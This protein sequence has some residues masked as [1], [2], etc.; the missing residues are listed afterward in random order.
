MQ[1]L[2]SLSIDRRRNWLN[3]GYPFARQVCL[4]SGYL[5]LTWRQHDT[6]MNLLA[7]LFAG[8]RGDNRADPPRIG[9]NWPRRLSSR[10]EHWRSLETI[11]AAGR[12]AKA[13][14]RRSKAADSRIQAKVFQELAALKGLRRNPNCFLLRFALTPP[15]GPRPA[16]GAVRR[17]PTRLRACR[18]KKA[19][20]PVR[21][22]VRRRARRSQSSS[23]QAGSAESRRRPSRPQGRLSC[24]LRIP[25][26]TSYETNQ[27]QI[28]LHLVNWRCMPA[29]WASC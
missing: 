19:V 18:P 29:D 14:E 6:F 2:L 3:E 16:A 21:R 9:W 11:Q 8:W 28:R 17:Q 7:L 25:Y 12:S 15:L 26:A 22:R 24:R 4:R 10:L 27:E 13:R 20:D 1:A 23:A 5:R